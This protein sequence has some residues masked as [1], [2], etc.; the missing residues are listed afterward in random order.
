[1]ENLVDLA[2]T[3]SHLSMSMKFVKNLIIVMDKICG[4]QKGP[5]QRFFF[6]FFR[7]LSLVTRLAKKRR[8]GDQ[9]QRRIL[10]V[11]VTDKGYQ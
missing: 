7:K 2:C 4:M 6:F 1:M 11:R 8:C 3:Y 10:G 9:H 5:G